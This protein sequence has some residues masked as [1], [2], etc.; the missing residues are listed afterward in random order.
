[1]MEHLSPAQAG[2]CALAFVTG[3]GGPAGRATASFLRERKV[4]VA[5]A[6]MR[7]LE[8]EADL[9]LLPAAVAPEF[10]S[11]LRRALGERGARL[12]VPTVSEELPLVALDRETLRAAGC[13][14][15]ISPPGATRIA[16]DKWLTAEALARA[17]VGVPRSV[18]GGS[19]ADILEALSFPILSKPRQGRGGRGIEIYETK[20]DLPE[21]SPDRIYQQFLEGEEYDVNLFAEPGGHPA[22]LVVLRKTQ[23][24]GGR[25]GN[26]TAVERDAAPDVA[27]VAAAASR[28]LAL[29]GPIDIDVRR[30]ARGRPLVLEVNAR[31]GANVRAADEVLEALLDRWKEEV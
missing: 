11:Q 31:V 30:D 23:L 2:R 29:E 25:V 19:R 1:M 5:V 20:T 8:D 17:G 15:F 27:E 4:P 13:A 10:R 12:L 26:A 21:P 6:D 3:A 18:G 24:R 28:A 14:V 7:P 9:V 22:A 16:N